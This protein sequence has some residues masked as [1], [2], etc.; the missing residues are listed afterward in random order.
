MR[1]RCRERVIGI[2]KSTRMCPLFK[3]KNT[4]ELKLNL[5]FSKTFYFE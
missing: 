2:E 4:F 3:L 5:N 1:R